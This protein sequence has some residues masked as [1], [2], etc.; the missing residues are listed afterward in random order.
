MTEPRE[1]AGDNRAEEQLLLQATALQTVANS[2][3][4]T[5]R[6][7]TIVWVNRSFAELT[8]YSPEEAIGQNPR[9]LKSGQHDRDFYKQLW[10]TIL[11]GHTWRGDFTNRRKDGTFYD[12][13]HTITP[14]RSP[15][16]EITHFVAVMQDVTERKRAAH[17]IQ[18]LNEELEERVRSRTAELETANKELEAFSYSVSH[19]LRAPLRAI[20]GFA[21]ILQ[22]DYNAHLNNDGRHLLDTIN[23]EVR[24]MGQLI[25]DLLAFSRLSRQKLDKALV[26]MTALAQSVF[27][28]LT[29]RVSQKPEFDLQALPDAMGDRAMLRQVF[30]NLLSNAIKFSGT[31]ER[32]HIEV[33][34][35]ETG[36]EKHYQ[37]KDNGV[38][39]DDRF[40]EK[41]FGAFQRLHSDHE[42]E[43]TGVGLAL[44]ERVVRRHGGRVWAEG[45]V[46][47][48]ASFYF[49]LPV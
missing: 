4:I 44:V 43:G 30:S 36:R 42:F 45:K 31:R 16:G 11:S 28:D 19:D 49:A 32:P 39:Y 13:Q 46:N 37:V 41:L 5:D 22:E 40:A 7:G 27:D 35:W 18:R 38:G 17:Q 33:R 10:S 23:G 8:G 15:D 21:R 34:G 25:D 24:H 14:V 12:D 20:G 29:G 26:D 2:V 1:V 6:Y 48:G 9:L 47:Q 3:M